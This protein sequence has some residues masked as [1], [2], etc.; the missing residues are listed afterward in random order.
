MNIRTEILQSVYDAI[1]EI[2][3]IERPDNLDQISGIKIYITIL[4][5]YL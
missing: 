5:Y 2:K 3:L 4:N 1:H